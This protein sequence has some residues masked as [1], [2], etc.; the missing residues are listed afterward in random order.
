MNHCLEVPT[1]PRAI[2]AAHRWCLDPARARFAR[3]AKSGK[4]D[5][6]T[7]ASPVTTSASIAADAHIWGEYDGTSF[8]CAMSKNHSDLRPSL[9][10]GSTHSSGMNHNRLS[11]PTTLQSSAALDIGLRQCAFAIRGA[12]AT[13][14]AAEA[15]VTMKLNIAA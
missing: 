4:L 11:N 9:S 1:H 12:I 13:I 5:I 14:G 6:H 8:G 3:E 2:H 7:S 15:V 10:G